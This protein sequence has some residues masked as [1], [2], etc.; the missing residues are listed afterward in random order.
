MLLPEHCL[1]ETYLHPL[2]CQILTIFYLLNHMLSLD[3]KLQTD[4]AGLHIE[5]LLQLDRVV[6]NQVVKEIER[7]CYVDIVV[8]QVTIS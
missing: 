5:S 3:L 1:I 8:T 7:G 6:R 2:P 4:S